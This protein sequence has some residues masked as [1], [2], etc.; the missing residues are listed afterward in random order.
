MISKYYSIPL[1]TL[2]TDD[3]LLRQ[4]TVLNNWRQWKV[5]D[6]NYSKADVNERAY[7][8]KCVSLMAGA[9]QP[10]LTD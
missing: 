9:V 10:L 1:H 8:H 7:D 2:V 6:Q 3:R 4:M 5:N